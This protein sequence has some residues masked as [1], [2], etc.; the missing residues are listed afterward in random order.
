MVGGG[1]APGAAGPVSKGFI[2]IPPPPTSIASEDEIACI[3]DFI[4]AA[5]ASGTA[6]GDCGK[7]QLKGA[8]KLLTKAAQAVEKGK[9]K[10]A[11]DKLDDAYDRVNKHLKSKKACIAE[12]AA[13]MAK[14]I[15][16]VMKDLGCREHGCRH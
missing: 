10:K 13:E 9:T 11:C 16:D 12:V 15:Q 14:Q 5:L 8:E 7:V 2:A 4:D 1:T 6:T 3:L